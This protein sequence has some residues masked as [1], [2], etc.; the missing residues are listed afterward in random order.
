VLIGTGH[1][2]QGKKA[3]L[4]CC[5]SRPDRVV[6][7]VLQDMPADSVDHNRYTTNFT[8]YIDDVCYLGATHYCYVS[9][10]I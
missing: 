2:W 9:A 7:C 5:S 10:A 6:K 4:A 1:A 8:A 3:L